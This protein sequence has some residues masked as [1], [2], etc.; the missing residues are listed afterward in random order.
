VTTD[1]EYYR[2]VDH[3]D[4][5]DDDGKYIVPLDHNDTVT[6]ENSVTLKADPTQKADDD[7]DDVFAS[8]YVVAFE[9]YNIMTVLV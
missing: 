1:D 4:D 6:S 8:R 3:D 5:D 9:C 7:E 2:H